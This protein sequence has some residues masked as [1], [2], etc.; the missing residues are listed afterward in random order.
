MIKIISIIFI[1]LFLHSCNRP[2]SD[3][4]INPV[5]VGFAP[6]DI[7]TFILKEYKPNDNYTHLIDTFLITLNGKLSVATTSNDTTIV[8][9]YINDFPSYIHSG[10]DWQIYIPAK[11]KTVTIS[12]IINGDP[13]SASRGC[14][15]SIESFIQDSQLVVPQLMLTGN[16]YTSG[17]MAY[18]TN[19]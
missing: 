16:S 15:Y 1:F 6:S 3:N 8:S 4:Y 9:L 11:N 18:I 13:I 10:Y 19:H 17:Y 2:C 7:D 5:F 14:F 12:N